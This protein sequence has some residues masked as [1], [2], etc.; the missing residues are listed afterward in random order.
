VPQFPHVGTG[1]GVIDGTGVGWGLTGT[2]GT[3]DGVGTSAMDGVGAS[4]GRGVGTMV[5]RFGKIVGAGV[6]TGED[7][8]ACPRCNPVRGTTSK[9]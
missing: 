9:L 8:A 1:C 3:G 4:D 2:V 5:G 7:D 6:G